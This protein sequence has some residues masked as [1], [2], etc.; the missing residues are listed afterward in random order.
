MAT[1]VRRLTP[2]EAESF[3]DVRL[4]GVRLQDREFRFSTEDELAIPMSA[5]RA[6]METDFIV[7]A[8]VGDELVGIGG[9][10]RQA[11]SKLS[12]R[13]LLWGMYIKAAH[14]RSGLSDTMMQTLLDFAEQSEIE[15]V[16]LTVVS[17]N[18]VAS[19][20]YSRWG[21]IAYGIDRSVVKLADGS[22]LDETLMVRRFPKNGGSSHVA[23]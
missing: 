14:R 19:R 21:F 15:S 5:L 16:I 8:F 1:T 2:E 12:H 22:Y 4:E 11:G 18:E 9:L 6:R 3:R 10:T 13:A 23:A 7:G 17:H 20:F